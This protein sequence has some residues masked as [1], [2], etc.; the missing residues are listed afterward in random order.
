[1]FLLLQVCNHGGRSKTKLWL[2]VNE[3][4]VGR[5]GKKKAHTDVHIISFSYTEKPVMAYLESIQSP[6]KQEGQGDCSNADITVEPP[7]RATATGQIS[8]GSQGSIWA[9][10]SAVDPLVLKCFLQPL[11]YNS[12]HGPVRKG[13]QTTSGPLLQR[14][15]PLMSALSYRGH[16]VHLVPMKLTEGSLGAELSIDSRACK[17]FRIS[18][19]FWPKDF[20]F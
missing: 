15:P 16:L 11:L 20:P 4:T 17:Q 9:T 2:E 3:R 6:V 12:I 5:G 10:C 18:H 1:M 14:T 7:A 8:L 19:W 13:E